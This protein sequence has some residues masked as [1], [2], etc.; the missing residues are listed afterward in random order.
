MA[1]IEGICGIW[2]AAPTPAAGTPSERHALIQ[3]S[4]NCCAPAGPA[5]AWV[6]SVVE[7]VLEEVEEC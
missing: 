4:N 5:L 6:R 7:S 1:G 2:N 3:A